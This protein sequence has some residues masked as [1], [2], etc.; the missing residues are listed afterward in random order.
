MKP[1]MYNPAVRVSGLS[2]FFFIPFPLF[3]S[4]LF[5][6]FFKMLHLYYI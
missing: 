2:S 1:V 6:R 3:F 4:M 5:I